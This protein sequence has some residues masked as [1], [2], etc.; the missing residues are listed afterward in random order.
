MRK[1]LLMI[2]SVLV[3]VPAFCGTKLLTG[4][5]SE[6]LDVENI[7]VS[8]DWSNAVYKKGGT[9]DD[10]IKKAPRSKNW[11]SESLAFFLREANE[12]CAQYGTTLVEQSDANNAPYAIIIAVSKISGGGDIE[13]IIKLI[14]VET[15]GELATVKFSSDESDDNDN[16]AFKDQLENVGEN[17]GSIL[18]KQLKKAS[19]R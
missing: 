6:I 16:I 8:I 9:L 17:F 15:N 19:K 2:L 13:G 3:A 14:N 4:D 10:F 18:K 11:E 5:F 1:F 7:P 12:R